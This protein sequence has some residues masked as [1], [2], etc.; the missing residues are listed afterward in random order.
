MRYRIQVLLISKSLNT[1]GKGT[2]AVIDEVHNKR[3]LHLEGTHYEMGYQH[4]YL[5]AEEIP[6]FLYEYAREGVRSLKLEEIGEKIAGSDF[7]NLFWPLIEPKIKNIPEEFMEEIEG[8]MDGVF[9]AGVME[10][11]SHEADLLFKDIIITSMGIDVLTSLFGPIKYA[12]SLFENFPDFEGSLHSC[13]GFVATGDAT[14]DGGVIMGRDFTFSGKVIA[15]YG[16]II[17]Y[18]PQKEGAKKLVSIGAPGFVI[19]QS[20]LNEN[21]LAI[22]AHVVYA[23]DTNY[24]KLGMGAGFLKR[25]IMQYAGE[26]SE[27]V[28]MIKNATLGTSWS[29]LLGDGQGVEQGGAFV[30]RSAHHCRVRYMDYNFP[31][32][33]ANWE[34]LPKQIEDNPDLVLGINH[35][36]TPWMSTMAMGIPLTIDSYEELYRRLQDTLASEKINPDNGMDLINYRKDYRKYPDTSEIGVSITLYD[37]GNMQFRTLYGYYDHPWVTYRFNE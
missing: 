32:L 6:G 28:E 24:S 12:S 33:F 29:F 20:G 14:Q 3:I 11:G 26:F 1:S 23:G 34:I 7:E 30:E 21:G 37:L 5:L 2:L 4:G 9:A 8:I 19:V 27:A 16:L 25:H 31:S 15:D 10:K 17:E 13:S 22:G 18:N 35:F 36:I